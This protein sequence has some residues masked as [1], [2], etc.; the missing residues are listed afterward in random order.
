[1]DQAQAQVQPQ[2]QVQE[3]TWV[4]YVR[5]QA[6]IIGSVTHYYFTGLAKDRPPSQ[7]DLADHWEKGGGQALF[8]ATHR[9][10]WPEDNTTVTS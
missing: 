4:E 5:E 10:R 3:M 8:N 7:V 2:V 9:V 6:R 1:M